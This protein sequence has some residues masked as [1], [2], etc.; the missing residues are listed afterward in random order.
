ML[1]YKWY[2]ILTS[3]LFESTN[4]A[5][6][7]TY[8]IS[9]KCFAGF[10]HS[11]DGIVHIPLSRKTIHGSVQGLRH[12]LCHLHTHTHTHTHTQKYR[13][14][15]ISA[16]LTTWSSGLQCSHTAIMNS[17]TWAWKDDSSTVVKKYYFYYLFQ[18][19]SYLSQSPARVKNNVLCWTQMRIGSDAWRDR[20]GFTIAVFKASLIISHY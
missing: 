16:G 14:C 3:P 9:Q 12:C 15:W 5:T 17:P 4:K 10:T 6:F 11:A 19:R 8:R 7:P 13:Q 2:K 18:E 20:S 1:I